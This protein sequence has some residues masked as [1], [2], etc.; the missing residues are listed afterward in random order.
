MRFA[1]SGLIPL[2]PVVLRCLC[3]NDWLS[4]P[5]R[6]AF[7]YLCAICFAKCYGEEE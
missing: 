7:D 2:G 6:A 4:G 5:E 1:P 3:C